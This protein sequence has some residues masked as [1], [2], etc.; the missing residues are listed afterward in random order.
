[1]TAIDRLCRC[2]IGPRLFH[3]IL[4]TNSHQYSTPTMP[5]LRVCRYE[6]N[7][8]TDDSSATWGVCLSLAS[9]VV[10]HSCYL[11]GV[12]T[13]PIVLELSATYYL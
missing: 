2:K 3:L 8:T 6:H 13:H 9:W 4:L 7:N 12:M 11:F 1:M 5:I 10:Q